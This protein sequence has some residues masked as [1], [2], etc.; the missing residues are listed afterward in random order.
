MTEEIK[1]TTAPEAGDDNTSENET[2]SEDIMSELPEEVVKTIKSLQAQKDHFRGKYDKTN[3]AFEELQSKV[4]SLT[5]PEEPEVPVA[6][7]ETAT[8]DEWKARMEFAMKHQGKVDMAD[9]DKIVS[10]SKIEGKTLDETLETPLYKGYLKA[11][12]D[13]A[14]EQ[15]TTP[16]AGSESPVLGKNDNFSKVTPEDIPNMDKET[17][18]KYQSYLKNL[19]PNQR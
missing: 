5:K 14:A 9:L 17:F 1:E 3:T 19:S 12:E 7:K 13:S 11:K 4:G 16:S 18:T 8:D 2:L 10:I 15:G 6:T